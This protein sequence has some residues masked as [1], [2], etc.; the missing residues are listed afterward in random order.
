MDSRIGEKRGIPRTPVADLPIEPTTL[1]VGEI[2]TFTHDG[3]KYVPFKVYGSYAEAHKDL[4][5]KYTFKAFLDRISL[6]SNTAHGTQCTSI[7]AGATYMLYFARNP[8]IRTSATRAR[9]KGLVTIEDTVTG[10]ITTY[11]TLRE[12]RLDLG[13]DKEMRMTMY[14]NHGYLILKRY[15]ITRG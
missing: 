11:N 8:S 7:L 14:I 1:P 13:L 6:H 3:S 4:G 2:H 5:G 12:M 10:K 9:A 15:R